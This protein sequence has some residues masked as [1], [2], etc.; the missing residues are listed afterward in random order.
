M[1]AVCRAAALTLLLVWGVAQAFTFPNLM[2]GFTARPGGAQFL[3]D[4][5]I[6]QALADQ[7]AQCDQVGI[8][9]YT[10]SAAATAGLSTWLTQQ[11][12]T[13]KEITRTATSVVWAATSE[14]AELLGEWRAPALQQP[15]RLE[16][17][18]LSLK[19]DVSVGVP[20]KLLALLLGGVGALGALAG[21]GWTTWS[22]RRHRS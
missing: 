10:D 19:E 3:P 15:G 6:H 1:S 21:G 11:Q 9:E 8:Y 13:S 4:G 7:H 18:F 22:R 14:A 12:F 17:C 2:P 20:T 16:L 5:Q